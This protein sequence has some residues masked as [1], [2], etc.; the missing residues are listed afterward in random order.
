MYLIAAG[1]CFNQICEK[2][3]RTEASKSSEVPCLASGKHCQEGK[4]KKR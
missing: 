4:M 2:F 3:K 1:S